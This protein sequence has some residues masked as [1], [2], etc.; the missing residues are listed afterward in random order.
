MLLPPLTSNSASTSH[1]T[2]EV[3]ENEVVWDITGTVPL[4]LLL[5]GLS[6]DDTSTVLKDIVAPK[7]TKEFRPVVVNAS[8]E[9]YKIFDFHM[10]IHIL[11]RLFDKQEALAEMDVSLG[12]LHSS[13]KQNSIV[14]SHQPRLLKSAPKKRKMPSKT[15]SETR[16]K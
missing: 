14:I 2:L 6:P 10:P 3:E 5:N 16:S 1:V 4:M 12:L 13:V 15:R 8:P 7:L 11:S 9:G